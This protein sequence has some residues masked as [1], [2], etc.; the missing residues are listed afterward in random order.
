MKQKICIIVVY[1][2]KNNSFF[3]PWLFTC[4]MNKDIDFLVLTDIQI[5]CSYDNVTIITYSMEE[6]NN[7]TSRTLG[8]EVNIKKP[9][10]LCDF[11]PL[12]GL[13]FSSYLSAYDYWGYCDID[14]LF[15]DISMFLSIHDFTKYDRFLQNGHLSIYKNNDKMNN[16]FKMPG[17]K[18]DYIHS[19]TSEISMFFD[20][21]DGIN[22]ICD[23][24]NIYRFKKSIFLDIS[25]LHRELVL[26][27]AKNYKYQ[28][29]KYKNGK[30]FHC[31]FDSNMNYNEKE[32]LYIHYQKR[33]FDRIDEINSYDTF[34]ICK[35]GIIIENSP[36]TI[37]LIKKYN[38]RSIFIIYF[39]CYI[40]GKIKFKL[41]GF[42]R[43]IKLFFHSQ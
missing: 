41:N 26:A 37:D 11:R 31:Y 4:S 32:Y 25:F 2:G 20:E 1:F 5:E 15:G 17:A 38:K 35:N 30:L 24:N 12:F 7:I 40:T 6:F 23:K 16:L 19:I 18:H 42:R 43:K 22:S 28:I 27:H 36:I 21:F 3:K 10:K 9:Y 14:M 8:F 34:L 39:F 33:K 29:F 13:I